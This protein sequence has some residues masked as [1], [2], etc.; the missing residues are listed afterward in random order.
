MSGEVANRRRAVRYP[1]R[2][3][4]CRKLQ[5]ELPVSR[6]AGELQRRDRVERLGRRTSEL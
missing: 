4:I 5:R 6:G 2:G 3:H 1:P